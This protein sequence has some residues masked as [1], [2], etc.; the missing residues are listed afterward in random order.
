MSA[1]TEVIPPSLLARIEATPADL[2]K[3]RR[4]LMIGFDGAADFAEAIRESGEDLQAGRWMTVEEQDTQ[5]K[6]KFPWLNK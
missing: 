6:A 5:L 3:A 1:L 2:E 4:L